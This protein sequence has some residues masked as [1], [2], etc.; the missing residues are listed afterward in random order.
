MSNDN[1]KRLFL[2]GTETKYIIYS[3]GRLYSENKKDFLSQGRKGRYCSY[4]ISVNG[5]NYTLYAHRL[6]AQYF[7]PNPNELKE[8]NHIN[9][10]T[11]DNRVENLEW[12]SREENLK[13]Q[14]DNLLYRRRII[15][16]FDLFG[17]FI[18]E[19]KTA[20]EVEEKLGFNQKAINDCIK[21]N[22]ANAYGYIWTE[23]E[24]KTD[25]KGLNLKLRKQEIEMLDLNGNIIKTFDKISDVYP[26]LNKRDNGVVSQVVKGRRKT[27]WGYKFRYK[28]IH[29]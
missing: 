11:R 1:C 18:Q 4:N 22:I 17:N 12:V 2:D 15:K 5:K 28:N 23:D 6:V 14:K 24:N 25:F 8:V 13:H 21:G 19:F 27:A 7:I 9:G 10:N 26:Y 3:D 20:S 29:S 16:Q